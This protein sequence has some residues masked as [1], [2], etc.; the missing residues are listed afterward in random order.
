MNTAPLEQFATSICIPITEGLLPSFVQHFKELLHSLNSWRTQQ[1]RKFSVLGN[2]PTK[3][4][5][6]TITIDEKNGMLFLPTADF[7]PT[8]T[9][10]NGRP[11]M[12]PGTFQ[13][14]VVQ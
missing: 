10:S 9:N 13:V 7:D 3:R 5:A 12:M 14:L 8:K 11:M 2:Y 1:R 4:G 6:R